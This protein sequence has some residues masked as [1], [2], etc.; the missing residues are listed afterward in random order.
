MHR[1]IITIIY[2]SVLAL[3]QKN[4][5]ITAAWGFS[6]SIGLIDALIRQQIN[7][8]RLKMP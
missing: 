8:L 2:I 5:K 7:S 3:N 4:Y 6:F 1:G